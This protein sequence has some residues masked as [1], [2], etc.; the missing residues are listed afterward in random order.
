[1][2]F[3]ITPFAMVTGILLIKGGAGVIGLPGILLP[4]GYVA[5]I[6]TE[7]N[8]Q[9]DTSRLP[10]TLDIGANHK[11]KNIILIVD[12]SISG[13]F[14][15][16]SDEITITPVLAEN[17]NI[18]ADFGQTSS[19]HN[20]SSFSNASIRWGAT[21]DN[22]DKLRELTTVW[23]YAS[24][25]GYSTAYIDAQKQPGS[26]GN[27]MTL[28]EARDIDAFIQFP[29][30]QIERDPEYIRN[31]FKAIDSTADILKGQGAHFIYINKLG[32]HVP[33]EGKY[34]ENEALFK[35]HMELFEPIG[36]T[37]RK[38]LINSYKNVIHWNLQQ[39]FKL[40]LDRI[41]LDNTLVIYTSD[42][43]QN[44][45]EHGDATHCSRQTESQ[46][47][48]LVPLLA[49]TKNPALLKK[50]KKSASLN[51]GKASNFNIFPTVL[52]LMGY[53]TEQVE[54]SYTQTLNSPIDRLG[55]FLT[56]DLYS[57]YYWN[58]IKPGLRTRLND[59][60]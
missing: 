31:D 56:G 57:R 14:I 15:N 21:P 33:Y 54:N 59:I 11:I 50:F 5:A 58:P 23:Q 10:V 20:C 6:T 49:I 9:P 18:I 22:L 41:D 7:V 26:Y 12:E 45:L 43:G 38:E 51:H 25:A 55:K 8:H 3:P 46:Y 1:M 42:H 28:N 24:K 4:A 13:D 30:P 48:A 29:S 53:S 37:T 44:L 36:L 47:Q 34:P 39:F 40:L 19:I 17:K 35:P 16:L 27:F 60:Q 52:S 2:L 32:A